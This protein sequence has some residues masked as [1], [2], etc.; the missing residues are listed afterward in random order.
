MPPGSLGSRL[1]SATRCC[2]A[3]SH[4]HHCRQDLN[5]ERQKELSA[6]LTAHCE[7]HA[8]SLSGP[9]ATVDQTAN[10]G[11]LCASH[12]LVIFYPNEPLEAPPA[13]PP[14]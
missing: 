4:C 1:R 3:R 14:L 8:K 10:F 11:H 13:L 5:Q 6:T 2:E 9:E 12:A 7:T